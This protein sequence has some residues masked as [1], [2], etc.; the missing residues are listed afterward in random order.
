MRFPLFGV[1][2]KYIS[3]KYYLAHVVYFCTW[4]EGTLPTMA[5]NFINK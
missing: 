1:G 4:P 3:L 5:I 2:E